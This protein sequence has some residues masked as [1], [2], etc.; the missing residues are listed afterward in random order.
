MK[1]GLREDDVEG[2]NLERVPTSHAT[3][4]ARLFA[5]HRKRGGSREDFIDFFS[6][7]G[8]AL[9]LSTLKRWKAGLD[10]SGEALTDAGQRGRNS[11]LTDEEKRLLCGF[12]LIGN[13]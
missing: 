4:V 9:P 6:E 10:S 7:A 13:V 8:Y 11:N 3:L 5:A 2:S 12:V 1:R